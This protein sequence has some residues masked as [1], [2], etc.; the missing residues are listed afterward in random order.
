MSINSAARCLLHFILLFASGSLYAGTCSSLIFA[1]GFEGNQAGPI[2]YTT[3]P[4][5]GAA[6]VELEDI[7][8]ATFSRDV[9]SDSISDSTFQLSQGGNGVAGTVVLDSA[10]NRAKLGPVKTLALLREYRATLTD[11]ITDLSGTSLPASSWSF[12]SR[13][14]AWSTIGEVLGKGNS[15]PESYPHIAANVK[16]EAV[17]VWVQDAGTRTDIWASHYTPRSGWDAAQLVET[18]TTYPSIN[19][20]VAMDDAGNAIAV[21][22][23]LDVSATYSILA[24]R[25]EFGNGW[26]LAEPLETGAGRADEQRVVAN[27]AGD[28]IVVWSQV[29]EFGISSIWAN[30]FDPDSGWS[31]AESVVLSL[32]TYASEPEVAINEVGFGF[33]TWAQGP[34]PPDGVPRIWTAQYFP[35]GGLGWANQSPISPV[36][37]LFAFSPKIFLDAGGRATVV[38]MQENEF[39]FFLTDIWAN[40]W[41]EDTRFRDYRY[42]GVNFNVISG[43]RFGPSDSLTGVFRVDCAAAGGAG[44]CNSLPSGDYS[45]AVTFLTFT[46]SGSTPLTITGADAAS[47]SVSMQTDAT[48]HLTGP[49]NI[50][51]ESSLEGGA[52]ARIESNDTG[53]STVA[54]TGAAGGEGEVSYSAGTFSLDPL[55]FDWGTAE[56]LETD[57]SSIA[58]P[59]RIEG[60]SGGS[61]IAIW[62]QGDEF[63]T[64]PVT[65]GPLFRVLANRFSIDNGWSGPELVAASPDGDAFSPEIAVDDAGNVI[66]VWESNETTPNGIIASRYSPGAGWSSPTQVGEINPFG[67]SGPY[68]PEDAS[69]AESSRAQIAADGFGNMHL[70]WQRLALDP[71]TGTILDGTI[72][73]S[74]FGGGGEPN[75]KLVSETLFADSVL[76]DCI[77]ATAAANSWHFAQEVTSLDCSNRD[78]RSL[79][80]METFVNLVTLNLSS[81]S[82]EDV[83]VI[84]RF[85]DLRE[86]NL[87]NIPVLTDI[88]AL[89]AQGQLTTVDLSGSGGGRISC[90]DLTV[91]GAGVVRPDDCRKSIAEVT[92]ADSVLQTCVANSLALQ[93]LA[94]LDELT[95]L[96]C[97]RRDGPADIGRIMQLD[98]IEVLVN[99]K[100]VNI[101]RSGVS[102]LTPL[103][104]LPRLKRIDASSTEITSLDAIAALPELEVLILK[105]VAGLYNDVV[106]GEDPT[107]ISILGSMPA[108]REVYLEEKGYCPAGAGAQCWT[109]NGRLDCQTL[110]NLEALFDDP[111][112]PRVFKRPAACNMPLADGL[113]GVPDVNLKNCLQSR[114]DIEGL[115]DT[116]GFGGYL[117]CAASG[118]TDLSGLENFSRLVEL[119]LSSNPISDL[120]PLNSIYTLQKLWLSGT[121]ITSFDALTN[122]IFLRT[123]VAT[124]IPGLTD[125]S[126]LL[127]M[128]TLGQALTFNSILDPGFLDLRESGNFNIACD[129]VAVLRAIVEGNPL[130][131]GFYEPDCGGPP[132]I[133]PVEGR[134][135]KLNPDGTDDLI[136]QF[137]AP[138]G[139]AQTSSWT[140]A[141]SMSPIFD[142]VSTLPAYDTS[143]YSRARAIGLADANNDGVDDLL[144]QLDAV[145]GDTVDLQVWLNR[146]DGIFDASMTPFSIPDGAMNNAQAVGFKDVDKDGRAD[147]LIQWQEAPG[148]TSFA[149]YGLLLNTG[150][151]FVNADPSVGWFAIF[152]IDKAGRPRVIALEDVNGDDFADLVYANEII[153]IESDEYQ[154]FCFTVSLWDQS[155]QRFTGNGSATRCNGTELKD[156]PRSFLES[157]SVADV[158][159]N[160]RKELLLSIKVERNLERVGDRG[161]YFFTYT[162]KD[163][164]Q[165]RASWS[166]VT[167]TSGET[168]DFNINV[169]TNYR[170]VAVADINNDRHSDLIVEREIEGQGKTWIAFLA[171][172]DEFGRVKFTA[173]YGRIASPA[174]SE[175]YMAIGL[176]DFDDDDGQ[177][178]PDL[179]FRRMDLATNMYEIHVATNNGVDFENSALW[180]SGTEMPGIIGLEEDGLTAMAN[181]TSELLAW[182]GDT[183]LQTRGEFNEYLLG[184][185]YELLEK[186]VLELDPTV[187]ANKCVLGYG[188]ADASGADSIDGFNQYQASAKMA[189]LTCNYQALDG[190]VILKM[191][192]VY[193][194]CAATAGVAGIGAKCE[195]G[196]FKAETEFIISKPPAAVSVEAEINGPK[197][198][199]CAE[200]TLTNFCAGGSAS[201]ADTSVG[202]N[203]GGVGAS[204]GVSAGSVGGRLQAGWQ[205]GAITASVGVELLIGVEFEISVNPEEVAES[206]VVVGE[207]S[208]TWAKTGVNAAGDGGEFVIYTAGPAIYGAASDA[209]SAVEDAGGK[210]G[211]LVKTAA[212]DAV[213]FFKNAENVRSFLVFRLVGG[214]TI[215][216]IFTELRSAAKDVA[217]GL[218]YVS[219]KLFSA[220]DSFMSGAKSLW[221][222]IF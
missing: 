39:D 110:D 182:S 131:I 187:G 61:V 221:K 178:L 85:S 160:G 119:E 56:P 157:A 195:A 86:L 115:N 35:F 73:F 76:R 67:I 77:V 176:L 41:R 146:G 74:R 102:D 124:S 163:E 210:A 203:I 46:A 139:V 201:L 151:G 66:A 6:N 145:T 70:V 88:S 7:I 172:N 16:G 60:N 100:V 205:D 171:G 27:A 36:T 33:A 135:T 40:R 166:D 217:E 121:N 83:S 55:S 69:F 50:V 192:A 87:S 197:V 109:G 150:T 104:G 75:G 68:N 58:G 89:V 49:Y 209:A 137:E 81:N 93:N 194:G 128:T 12:T 26:G 117:S 126:E 173:D 153:A 62:Q 114:A 214:L 32:D 158:N 144:L 78:V 143:I 179:L 96:D 198:S 162:L 30:Q 90:P 177:N 17:A 92:F 168:A 141:L 42:S 71:Q 22:Q 15:D 216:E 212:G 31:G 37:G 116:Q 215:E 125:I 170:T 213:S 165:G 20:Q 130:S 207:T 4:V 193:G 95:I 51:L 161:L 94:F 138:E 208:Y 219:G 118:V 105:S 103:A 21:W 188:D 13:D 72:Q 84:T 218:D 134:S 63:E 140:T 174:R 196:L 113:A 155:S 52:G 101:D 38:W 190:R 10:N 1:S 122:L 25:Y 11:C 29:D 80:G 65:G 164:G 99:L 186:T 111:E 59:P 57:E 123:I 45:S 159:G 206:F 147:I 132:E 54:R 107:G 220:G 108:L 18:D 34:L 28:A 112:S 156:L 43:G 180:Y 24:S 175:E 91:L 183:K 82:I 127:R 211:K 48:G 5:D 97:F 106:W 222:A 14:G 47:L 200:V 189:L 133:P 184:K 64:S 3:V 169:V 191:Q 129:A 53:G 149:F 199:G 142:D 181:D 202:A 167:Q 148:D 8:T 152:Q 98:G 23:Q 44:D 2:N 79:A 19:P 120:T 185:G 9:A 154:N 204:T 136:L